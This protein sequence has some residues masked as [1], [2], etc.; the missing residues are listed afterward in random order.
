MKK[1]RNYIGL[2][3]M[4]TIVLTSCNDYLNIPPQGE[5]L[6]EVSLSHPDSFERVLMGIYDVAANSFN[7]RVQFFGELLGPNMARPNKNDD[8][9]EVFIRR[10]NFFN[11]TINSWFTD[12]NR[13]VYR[14]NFMADYYEGVDFEAGQLERIKAE[15]DFLKAL[16]LFNQLQLFAQ[17]YGY[18]S[19]NSHLGIAI[20]ETA[21]ADPVARRTVKECYDYILGLLEGALPNLPDNGEAQYA[22]KNACRALLA[23]MYMQMSNYTKA[24]ELASEIIESGEY[25]LGTNVNRFGSSLNEEVIFGFVSTGSVDNRGSSFIDNY[26][27]DSKQPTLSFSQE[28]YDMVND[29][30]DRRADLFTVQN[31]GTAN[32]VYVT[33]KHDEDF[34]SVP[35]FHL[36]DIMLLRA[37]CYALLS[38]N[39][40]KAI[41]DVNAVKARAYKS[42]VSLSSGASATEVL[43][44]ARKERRIEM[45]GEGDWLFQ[46]KRRG[47]E[48]ENLTIRDADWNCPGMVLQFPVS[49]RSQI[50]EMNPEGGCN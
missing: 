48:G 50:F 49:E 16:T 15:A 29:T 26:R 21:T 25:S 20:R 32:Q 12:M 8:L 39:L 13:I 43:T 18:T 14:A 9:T 40:D 4:G 34:Q 38:S 22:G 11:G 28:V 33:T 27:Q 30:N 24:A 5:D 37:E 1:I 44:E 41:A 45:L 36:T 3:L 46:L 10:T 31:A 17:P 23:K 6:S 19:D 42:D 2:V 47:A 35:I 7:G